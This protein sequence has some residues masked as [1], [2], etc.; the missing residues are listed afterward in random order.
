[1]DAGPRR[2]GEVGRD[3]APPVDGGGEGL[4][5]SRAD[6]AG[7]VD[8]GD[9]TAPTDCV[10]QS[11]VIGRNPTSSCGFDLPVSIDTYLINIV[12]YSRLGGTGRVV[13]RV[14]GSGSCSPTGGWFMSDDDSVALCDESCLAFEAAG[15][16]AVVV[17]ELG[18]GGAFCR[19]RCM[20]FDEACGPAESC[21][22]GYECAPATSRCEPCRP[23][24]ASCS[25]DDD[26]RLCCSNFCGASGTCCYDF[27]DPCR[28][29]AD[30][31]EGACETGFCRCAP[32]EERCGDACVDVSSDVT[33]CGACGNTCGAGATCASGAC[34]CGGGLLHC[35]GTCVDPT[36]DAANCGSCGARCRADQVCAGSA[37]ACPAGQSECSGACRNLATDRLHCGACG[38]ACSSL[39]MCSGGTCVCRS[40]LM[41]CAGACVD[42]DTNDLHCGACGVECRG[43]RRCVGGACV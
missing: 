37:C 36:T 35:S 23:V 34:T 43:A 31:C 29:D 4:D 21:C 11:V 38:R 30:C 3:G 40:D 7:P 2:D 25:S 22:P 17:A 24:G 6:G 32:G 42:T 33:S 28:D 15:P 9:P 27:G 18:C 41:L 16:E 1:M 19:D 12:I 14:A 20:G 10:R 39:E 5:G 26:R 13:C 8:A